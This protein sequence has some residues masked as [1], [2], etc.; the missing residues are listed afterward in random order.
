MGRGH[1]AVMT[2]LISSNSYALS[3]ILQSMRYFLLIAAP[4]QEVTVASFSFASKNHDVRA[5]L[6]IIVSDT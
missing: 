4:H 3:I 2:C 1:F 5:S 6:F